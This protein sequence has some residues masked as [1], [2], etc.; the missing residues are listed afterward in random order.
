MLCRV[1]VTKL[2]ERYPDF[3]TAVSTI[4]FLGQSE[5]QN[6]KKKEMSKDLFIFRLVGGFVGESL[7]LF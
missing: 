7:S 4:F 6:C 2:T 5:C 1:C 3:R